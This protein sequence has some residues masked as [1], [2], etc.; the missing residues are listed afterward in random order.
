VTGPGSASEPLPECYPHRFG[1]SPPLSI[2]VE[3]ELLLV[4]EERRLVPASEA[5]IDSISGPLAGRVSSE[6]F[7]EQIEL[8]TGV[9]HGAGEVLR[10]L[11]EARRA[12]LEA[13]FGLLGSGLHPDARSGDVR[14][15]AKPRYEIVR[16]DLGSLLRT[17]PCGLHVHIGMTSDHIRSSARSRCVPSTCRPTPSRPLRSRR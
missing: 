11:G 15:V 7:T 8:K 17:P 9:C 3:E 4:D 16:R 6:I 5:V 10:D 12:V 14:L 13:G 2:G 1:A